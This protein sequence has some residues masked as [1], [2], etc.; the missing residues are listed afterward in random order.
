MSELTAPIRQLLVKNVHFSW[1]YEQDK[2]LEDIKKVLTNAPVLGFFDVKKDVVLTCDASSS[3]LGACIMQDNRP[4][5]YASRSLTETQLS[6]AQMEK[7]LLA[8]VFGAERFSQYIYGKEV[9]VLTDHKPL[10]SCLKKPV[11]KSPVRIQRLLLRLQRYNLRLQY[12]PGFYSY[13]ERGSW[14]ILDLL[15]ETLL[16]KLSI[17]VSWSFGYVD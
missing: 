10:L 8:I 14:K 4:I 9:T 7:E 3:G 5:A 2:A 17:T 13:T 1:S 12:V 11:H 15:T 16:I 6:Y